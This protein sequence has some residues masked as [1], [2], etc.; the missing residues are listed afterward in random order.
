MSRGRLAPWRRFLVRMILRIRFAAGG[1]FDGANPLPR[2]RGEDLKAA[3]PFLEP[4][5]FMLTG[6]HGELTH[7]GVY[8]GD[9]LL[10][11]AMGTQRTMRGWWGSA[12]DA[13]RRPFRRE[14]L[15]GVIEEGLPAFFDRYARDVWVALRLPDLDTGQRAL[16]LDRVRSLVGKPYDYDFSRGDDEYYCTELV[17]EFL[18]AAMGEKAPA[19]PTVHHRIPFLIERDIHEPVALFHVEGIETAV[20]CR[21]AERRYAENLGEARRIG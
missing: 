5:D 3:L 21:A 17:L 10:V 13:L 18:R 1:A 16:G 14:Q 15:T 7:V 19:L 6:N 8:A 11:H 9:G 4:G 2:L 20:A 12:W